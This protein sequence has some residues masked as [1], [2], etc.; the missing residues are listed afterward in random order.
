M[1]DELRA[2]T[3]EARA[4]RLQAMSL[5]E[6][7]AAW[8]EPVPPAPVPVPATSPATDRL[9][10]EVERLRAMTPAE[11]VVRWAEIKAGW[12]VAKAKTR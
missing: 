5:D 1:N 3:P 4:A 9:L 10:R 7:M 6:L 11:R 2:M 8:P 12:A